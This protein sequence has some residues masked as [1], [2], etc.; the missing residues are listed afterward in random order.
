[1]GEVV[2]T[3]ESVVSVAGGERMEPNVDAVKLASCKP[4]PVGIIRPT[5]TRPAWYISSL[6]SMPTNSNIFPS[7]VSVPE[8]RLSL[9]LYCLAKFFFVKYQ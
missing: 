9:T 3:V 8:L 6:M 5:A 1:M 7:V 4:N 2:E